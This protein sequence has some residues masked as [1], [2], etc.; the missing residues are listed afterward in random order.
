MA[1]PYPLVAG[2]WKMNGLH[3]SQSELVSIIEAIAVAPPNCDVLICPPYTLTC[4]FSELASGSSLAIGA[5]DCHDAQSGAHTGDVSAEMLKDAGAEFVILG[6]SERRQDHGETSDAVAAKIKAATSQGLKVIL[7]VG[8]SDLQRDEGATIDVVVEQLNHSVPQE[9]DV[10]ALAIAYEPIWAI[11][12]G[13]VP[14]NDDISEVHH[15]IRVWLNNRFGLS[16]EAVR[17][18]YGG[19]VKPGNA[20]A[21]MGIENVDGALVGGASLK[22]ADF[23]GI[24][25]AYR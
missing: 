7:C 9:M 16:G 15:S 25:N 11:G 6:H 23:N 21:L 3:A 20:G 18:L 10:T 24:I 19:S 12:T 2:N 22:A 8:E 17:I 1:K 13:R 5:Q 4:R 14:S